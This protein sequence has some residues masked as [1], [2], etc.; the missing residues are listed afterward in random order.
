MKATGMRGQWAP[1]SAVLLAARSAGSKACWALITYDNRQYDTF[2]S[3][4]S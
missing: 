2:Y 1:S 4:R 3:E